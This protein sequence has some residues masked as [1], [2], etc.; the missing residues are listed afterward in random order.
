LGTGI[1]YCQKTDAAIKAAKDF[2]KS[3]SDREDN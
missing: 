2:L 3:L 1:T